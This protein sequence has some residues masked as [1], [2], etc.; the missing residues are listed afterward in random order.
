MD[1]IIDFLKERTNFSLNVSNQLL[2]INFNVKVGDIVIGQNVK[3]EL[4]CKGETKAFLTTCNQESLIEATQVLSL[5]EAEA[6][7]QSSTDVTNIPFGSRTHF[8]IN[9]DSFWN[10]KF[11]HVTFNKVKVV[12]IF[13]EETTTFRGIGVSDGD[14]RIKITKKDIL[15]LEISKWNGSACAQIL[16]LHKELLDDKDL[17]KLDY[18]FKATDV[19]WFI[20]KYHPGQVIEFI[21]RDFHSPH[22]IN[23]I[24]PVCFSLDSNIVEYAILINKN[25]QHRGNSFYL[26]AVKSE[27]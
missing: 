17:F 22:K 3:E 27:A 20:R 11:N 16:S 13:V 25:H 8:I 12:P 9:Q 21:E 19:K 7:V 24:A 2:S 26:L 1:Q 10:R 14:F 6:P 15:A 5:P 4:V 23:Q 18:P